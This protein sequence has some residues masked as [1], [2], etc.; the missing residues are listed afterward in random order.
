MSIRQCK[1]QNMSGIVEKYSYITSKRLAEAKMIDKDDISIYAYNLQVFLERTIAFAGIFIIAGVIGY[2]LETVI[3]VVSFSLIR[4][5]A[6]GYHCKTFLGCFFLSMVTI[7]LSIPMVMYFRTSISIYFI[8]VLLSML[9]VLFIGSTTDIDSGFTDEEIQLVKHMGRYM[10]VL[11]ASISLLAYQFESTRYISFYIG[12]SVIQVA[13]YLI[14][15]KIIHRRKT[16][17]E[18]FVKQ[19]PA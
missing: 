10:G 1:Y 15:A 8:A 14:I 19:D 18:E 5:F 11:I 16:N 6:G 13:F 3:F 12:T 9:L 7:L 17:H 4:E 2:L